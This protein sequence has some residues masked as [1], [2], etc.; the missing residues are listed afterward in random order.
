V[1]IEGPHPETDLLIKGRLESQA[2][3]VDGAVLITSGDA[4]TGRIVLAKVT[5]SHTYDVE[6]EIPAGDVRDGE[7]KPAER[8]ASETL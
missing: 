4:E 7:M 6:A 1:L 3:E 5:R 8:S 2:P